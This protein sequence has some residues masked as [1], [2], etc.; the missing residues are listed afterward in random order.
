MS[1]CYLKL[2]LFL[3]IKAVFFPLLNAMKVS[4]LLLIPRL[5]VFPFILHCILSESEYYPLRT[6]IRVTLYILISNTN[7]SLTFGPIC[8]SVACFTFPL[9][10]L[11][12]H[13]VTVTGPKLTS[14]TIPLHTELL[15]GSA[16]REY[17]LCPVQRTRH[18]GPYLVTSLELLVSPPFP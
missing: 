4:P 15:H 8:I 17:P 2:S 5:T 9:G 11:Q 12:C 14:P 6:P 1:S 3:N 16:L 10:C 18:R 7:I 13:R